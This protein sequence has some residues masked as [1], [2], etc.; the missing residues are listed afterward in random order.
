MS[1]LD[2]IGGLLDVAGSVIGG[3]S[4]PIKDFLNDTD[5]ELNEHFDSEIAGLGAAAA[6]ASV[7]LFPELEIVEL[8]VAIGNICELI[9][10]VASL[11]LG[12]DEIDVD[13][14]G[15]RAE[16][17]DK[18]AEEFGSYDEYVDYL[19]SIEPDH[20]RLMALTDQQRLP[21]SLAGASIREQQIAD[22]LGVNTPIETYASA[23]K[24]GM[25]PEELSGTMKAAVDHG[26]ESLPDLGDYFSEDKLTQAEQVEMRECITEGVSEA[27][28][29]M[30]ESDVNEKLF[31]LKN[32]YQS[33]SI[34][35]G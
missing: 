4:E 31:D 24:A 20:D 12:D 26:I 30:T 34:E 15:M 27:H 2:S 9:S 8:V 33:D 23:Y 35:E 13:D 16:L 10:E 1:F 29:E 28:P 11:I 5:N 6:I 25:S 32:T 17:S 22:R 3:L 21:Y 19:N 7:L 18:S 14:L